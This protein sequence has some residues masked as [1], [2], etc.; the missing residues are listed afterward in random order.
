MIISF[1]MSKIIIYFLQK[2]NII[3]KQ[4][5]QKFDLFVQIIQVYF[6]RNLGCFDIKLIRIK[7]NKKYTYLNNNQINKFLIETPKN[8]FQLTIIYLIMNQ[9]SI[10][11]RSQEILI[12]KLQT[13]P[14]QK[15]IGDAMF[16]CVN[17]TSFIIDSF[18]YEKNDIIFILQEDDQLNR[19]N[20]ITLFGITL[21]KQGKLITYNTYYSWT[22]QN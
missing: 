9:I 16:K 20:D 21:Y 4:N 3:Q 2:G 8:I 22:N 1:Y 14:A 7:A 17:L 12:S 18:I 5:E 11:P 19:K 15:E 10:K 6:I 13:I